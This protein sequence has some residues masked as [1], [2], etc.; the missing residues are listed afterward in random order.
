MVRRIFDSSPSSWQDLEAKVHLA[1]QE[2]GYESHKGKAVQT[3]RGE[4]EIDVLAI[5]QTTP[6]PTRVICECKYWNKMVPQ[7][8]VH[9]FRTVCSD[10]GAHFGL[11]ISKKGFQPGAARSR[12][13]TNIHLMDFD[14][15]QETYFGEWKS[16]VFI[17]LTR[18]RDQILPILRA[19]SGATEYG[20]DLID[21]P[22][23]AGIDP[24]KKYSM[25]FGL[26]GGYSNYFIQQETFPVT[27]SDPRGDPRTIRQITVKSHRHYL[28]IAKEAV[29]ECN[30]RFELPETYFS[31]SGQLLVPVARE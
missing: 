30:A 8:V 25:F 29:A 26:E 9:G 4:V 2:M 18:M 17:M 7:N 15:F 12:I 27:F 24:M 10:A 16:G 28:E 11:I 23:I 19:A 20:L 14:E 6:I 22:M 5:K 31:S 1:F 13:S 3:V 21:E